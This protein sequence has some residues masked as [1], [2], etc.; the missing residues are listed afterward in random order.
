MG[1]TV[2]TT[3]TFCYCSYSFCNSRAGNF[4]F[5]S[6][7]TDWT[8][9]LTACLTITSTLTR[10]L[11]TLWALSSA[12][13]KVSTTR[14]EKQLNGLLKTWEVPLI[15]HSALK[16]ISVFLAESLV[17]DVQLVHFYTKNILNSSDTAFIDISSLC[18]LSTHFR[19]ET[20]EKQT[21]HPL[22]WSLYCGDVV[23]MT[24]SMKYTTKHSTIHIRA[25]YMT[26]RLEKKIFHF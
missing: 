10:L 20:E 6:D 17:K 26:H 24:D 3:E 18:R 16:A 14:P 1:K 7:W 23:T 5:S 2:R 8:R 19:L 13:T 12:E 21:F 25:L 22:A 9:I 15:P 11:S 4:T